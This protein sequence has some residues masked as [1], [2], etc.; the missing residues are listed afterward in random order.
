MEETLSVTDATD[1][2]NE[3]YADEAWTPVDRQ[4][5]QRRCR[6]GYVPSVK[7]SFGYVIAKS[8][9]GLLAETFRGNKG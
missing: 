9:L 5:V 7:T 2:L 8:N 3:T 6:K 4:R 1:W